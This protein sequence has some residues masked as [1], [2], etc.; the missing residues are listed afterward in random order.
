MIMRKL[1]YILV[2]GTLLIAGSCKKYL[3][4]VPNDVLTIDDIFTSKVNVDAYLAN[5]YSSLPDELVQ[6]FATYA[7]S[8]VWTGA[9]DECK[10]NWDFV[11]DNQLNLSTWSNT[12]GTVENYW[13]NYYQAI[14]NATDFINRIDG[15]NQTQLTP[16]L[17]TVYKAEARGLRALY[18]FYLLRMFGPVV[19]VGNNLISADASASAIS[20]P[21]SPFDSCIRYV[22]SQ[23]DSAALDLPVNPSSVSQYGRMTQGIVKAYKVEALLLEASPLYNGNT[24]YANFKNHNG[25]QLI[26]QTYDAGKWAAAASAA[27]DFITA[28]VPNTY[29][30]YVEANA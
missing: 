30:L 4:T 20:L 13:A 3:N 1:S 22:V 6:R 29:S 17:N 27:K 18:Y 8:G 12:D 5:I 16:S 23:F 26:N 24:D 2:A 11:Y 25:S 9:S 21:R 10:Y 14:R 28:F 19:V 7:N 15:A